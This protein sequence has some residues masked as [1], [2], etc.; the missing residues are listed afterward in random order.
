MGYSLISGLVTIWLHI[1]TTLS[2][3]FNILKTGVTKRSRNSSE[4]NSCQ[5]KKIEQEVIS[6]RQTNSNLSN[7][8]ICSV[9][10]VWNPPQYN[11]P[12]RKRIIRT[13]H[14][15]TLLRNR[16]FFHEH[17]QAGKGQSVTR[18]WLCSS[19]IPAWM[20]NLNSSI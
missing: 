9:S 1:L 16:F 17:N 10:K 15:T 4:V 19:F 2:W 7:A 20:R 6:K 12:A 13:W 18:Y 5:K 11:L 3:K 8:K 14:G